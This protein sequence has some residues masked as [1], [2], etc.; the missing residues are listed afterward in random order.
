MSGK[1]ELNQK[2]YYLGYYDC[3]EN[4]GEHRHYPPAAVSKMSYIAEVMQKLGYDVEIVSMSQTTLKH[5]FPGKTM[6]LQSGVMLRLFRT[7]GTGSILRRI[8]NRLGMNFQLLYFLL[9]IPKNA[10]VVVY[11]SLGYA[12]LIHFIKRMKKLKLLIEV[13]EIYAD[14]IGDEEA[15]AKELSLFTLADGYIFPTQLLD[16]AVNVNNKPSVVIH[17]TYQA[18][19]LRK[20]SFDDDK[21][22][23]VYAGTLDPRKGSLTVVETAEYLPENYHVHILGHGSDEEKRQLQEKILG[24]HTE[25]A[26][27]V[28]YDGLLGGDDYVRFMQKCQLGLSPQAPDAPFNGTSFPSKI[29]SYLANGLRVVSVRI[30]AIER[31]AVGDLISYYEV[32]KPE[33]IA[34]AIMDVDVSASYDSRARLRE[35]NKEF[36]D[37]LEQLIKDVT[38]ED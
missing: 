9:M 18:E 37:N 24:Q 34:K 12:T 30:P 6:K 19:A 7:F 27:T 17:G 26:A 4:A 3:P 23:V 22:H 21:I 11:H 14:V 36:A 20:V 38:L 28:T 33:E 32:Q 31:S 2:I 5:M 25:N 13:E 35:L 10:T 29:L 1:Y 15:R 8:V 16:E